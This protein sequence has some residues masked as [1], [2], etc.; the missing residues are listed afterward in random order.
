M[1]AEEAN[2]SQA[3]TEQRGRA[4]PMSRKDLVLAFL[5]GQS[6]KF[7]KDILAPEYI[8]KWGLFKRIKVGHQA[9]IDIEAQPWD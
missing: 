3:T 5:L 9:C 4:A 2:K 7:N 8:Y 6:P 1:V